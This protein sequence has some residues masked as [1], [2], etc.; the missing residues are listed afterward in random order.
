MRLDRIIS[1]IEGAEIHGDG[2]TEIALLSCDS[3]Q[4]QPGALFT[5]LPPASDATGPA[6]PRVNGED[7]IPQAISQGAAAIMAE[8]MVSGGN[9][10]VVIV[11][12]ARVAIS[13][14]AEAFYGHP[15]KK[16]C[17]VGVTG[18]NGKTTTVSMIQ[19]ILAFAGNRCGMLGTTQCDDGLQSKPSKLTTPGP[20][21]F[22]EY[23]A[24]MVA[25]GCTHAVVEVS[26]HAL[27]QSRTAGT[28]FSAAV[29]TNLTRDHLDYH[30]DMEHYADAKARLFQ[31]VKP[32]VPVVLNADD[33]WSERM[34][35]AASGEVCYYGIDR[36]G[37]LTAII[38][39]MD[40]AGTEVE[41]KHAEKSINLQIG[42]IGRHNV[43]NLLAAALTC[44][45]LG[46][47]LDR[48]AAALVSFPGVPGRLE[49]IPVPEGGY[50]FVDYAHT[51]D[52]LQKMLEILRPLTEKKLSV[53][54]GCGGNRDRGKRPL[55]AR[56]AE[57]MADRVII[58]NDNPRQ[59][60]QEQIFSDIR[61]G[62]QNPN[63]VIFEPDR[64]RAITEAVRKVGAGDTLLVA[65]KGHEDYQILGTERIHLDDR[66]I[67]RT[68]IA[69]SP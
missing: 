56:I 34:A 61:A 46:I 27:S 2:K 50:V 32:G 64:A 62:F 45:K 21:E 25:H 14:A 41:L 16:L 52:A 58:T 40:L 44:L 4:V 36:Q 11:P 28:K 42:L 66:E 51:D 1:G 22:S 48:A 30:G 60:A 26:S 38:N 31:K 3:R 15:S 33:S 29:F 59:E 54:F 55:M 5:A 67:V 10:P 23:L 37:E 20:V 12:D 53:I 9:L 19:H 49:R 8:K 35:E 7:F 65:G 43:Y 6:A 68:A 39:K 17:L 47:P 57:E 63:A 18:T 24:R 69:V 13:M